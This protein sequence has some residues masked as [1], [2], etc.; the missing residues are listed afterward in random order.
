MRATN[1]ECTLG[2]KNLSIRIEIMHTRKIFVLMLIAA[3]AFASASLVLPV[4]EHDPVVAVEG[5]IKRLLG[6]EYAA[7]FD[8]VV[9]PADEV[10]GRDVFEVGGTPSPGHV[11]RLAGNT[12]VALASAL[13]WYLKYWCNA[14]VSWGRDGS[15]NQ[16]ASVPPPNSLPS[17]AP[18]PLR[19]VTPNSVRYYFN[20]CTFGYSTVWWNF[21]QWQE[22]VDRMA[23]NGINMPLAAVG[24]EGVLYALFSSLGIT[25][26]EFFDWM[27]GAAF[28]PWWRMNN[29]YAWGG[30]LDH[31]WLQTQMDLQRAILSAMRAYGMTPVLPGWSGR[32]PAAFRRV[33]PN[34]TLFHLPP[35]AGFSPAYSANLNIA[36]SDPLFVELGIA[37][38]SLT[39][40][41]FG[42]DHMY[43]SD[44][45]NEMDP[46]SGNETYL[47][48]S[49]AVMYASARGADAAAVY[50]MQGW[51]FR[52]SP[53]W[54]QDRARAFLSGLP[55]NAT[56]I[57]ELNTEQDPVWSK[58]ESFYGHAFVWNALM[59]FGGRRGLYGN[60]TRIATGPV[61]DRAVPNV[62]MVG[63]G[64]TP[65]AIEEIPLMFDLVW[66]MM[67]RSAPPP[68][69]HAWVQA[70][71]AR[72]YGYGGRAA[73]HL[74][75]AL[76]LLQT[77]AYT[78]ADI[79]ESP[80][81]DEP[82]LTS[83]SSRNTNATGVL[84]AL[85]EVVA[86]LRAGEADAALGPMSYDLTDL[87]RQVLVNLFD[88]WHQLQAARYNAFVTTHANTSA[89]VAPLTAG[90]LALLTDLDAVAG[91]NVNFLLGPWIADARRWADVPAAA[92][93]RELNAR[94][95][96]T[97]WG[98]G[99][100][101]G[102]DSI[103]DYAARHWQGLLGDYYHG[104]WALQGRY[105]LAA[106][107]T[108]VPANWTAYEA[109]LLAAEQA[110]S[111]A[112]KAYPTEADGEPLALAEAALARWAG[113]S[114]DGWQILPDT[115][116]SAPAP[117][118]Y[119]W[120]TDEAATLTL[121]N[122]APS[123]A[124]VSSAGAIYMDAAQRIARPGTTLYI[125]I[126]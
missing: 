93:N 35:W 108:G 60:L 11:V 12:G 57:L 56:L 2:S 104:R 1:T 3:G 9:I 86:G 25:D 71:G 107:A 124:A 34:A 55:V 115:D 31:Y 85:R 5:L 26:E 92:A 95:V 36:P 41:A 50:V 58:Y 74:S 61:I 51:L 67:W 22:E 52:F 27:S 81:E 63:F 19:T 87:T 66:E 97:L 7:A 112:T 40:E 78:V 113:A 47:A 39:M 14:S 121:C 103:N 91:A 102:A 99:G 53:F 6:A 75:A 10:S 23:L 30:P 125:K 18:L 126:T 105:M 24:Q 83:F 94:N 114:T 84:A 100:P 32:V 38:T 15:G 43:A 77:A 42:T 79:D 117:L 46:P 80:L 54:T 16:L 49:A 72:R 21:T 28:L 70:Y 8:L 101:G 69:M 120:T 122:A 88:D 17:A 59:V 44:L 82:S 68:D 89:D 65:E 109:E 98:P 48:E 119:A 110:F 62:T 33:R 4:R 64:T 116:V 73:P 118:F 123:C 13:N 90:M 106:L 20:V 111:A 29:M 37:Y 76:S 45:W 96:L